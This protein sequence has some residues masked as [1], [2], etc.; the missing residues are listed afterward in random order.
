MAEI[1]VPTNGD[2][3]SEDSAALHAI[4]IT[5]FLNHDRR[6]AIVLDLQKASS[7]LDLSASA[8]FINPALRDRSSLLGLLHGHSSD[9]AQS[10]KQDYQN[11]LTW[12]QSLDTKTSA[13][14]FRFAGFEWTC[15]T[16]DARWRVI[17]ADLIHDPCTCTVRVPEPTPKPSSTLISD[18]V[19]SMKHSETES[20]DRYSSR[21]S[22]HDSRST[23]TTNK[24]LNP[25]ARARNFFAGDAI[26]EDNDKDIGPNARVQTPERE[27]ELDA[28][29]RE[30]DAF[31]IWSDIRVAKRNA[32]LLTKISA[33]ETI[34]ISIT[35]NDGTIVFANDAWYNITG[36]PHGPADASAWMGIFESDEIPKIADVWKRI[37]VEQEPGYFQTPLKWRWD[38]PAP[39]D[40]GVSDFPVWISVWAYPDVSIHGET[41]GCCTV[42]TDVSQQKWTERLIEQQL[43]NAVERAKV[44]EQL[45]NDL[46]LT[47]S[48][49]R[50]ISD[51][52]PHGIFGK[53]AHLSVS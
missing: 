2:S 32:D 41:I 43:A 49:F 18:A 22:R 51:S 30:S 3:R 53:S 46:A 28:K 47:E 34:G 40:A 35:D 33:F 23:S 50:R 8:A 29:A 21:P 48:R 20:N 16:L 37:T 11:F 52:M 6:P 45:S 9:D 27:P 42:L 39:T 19:S 26:K 13:N 1:R 24:N 15:T 36:I 4:S 14:H 10:N 44:L 17:F 5:Q 38:S 25:L 31:G 7:P 12:S